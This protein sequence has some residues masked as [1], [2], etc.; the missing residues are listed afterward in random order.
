MPVLEATAVDA[1]GNPLHL[2]RGDRGA[3]G[4]R[5]GGRRLAPRLRG[6]AGGAWHA[7]QRFGGVLVVVGAAVLPFLWIPALAL[8]AWWWLRRRRRGDGAPAPQASGA[9]GRAVWRLSPD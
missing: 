8:L 3:A 1:N 4:A 2:Q 7:L 5:R 9:A 6:R